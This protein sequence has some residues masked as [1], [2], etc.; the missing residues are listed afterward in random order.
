MNDQKSYNPWD[1]MLEQRLQQVKAT[2]K[3]KAWEIAAIK[4]EWR[5]K[6][7]NLGKTTQVIGERPKF[8]PVY[9][10]GHNGV[11]MVVT[12]ADNEIFG[13]SGSSFNRKPITAEQL[14]RQLEYQKR[15]KEADAWIRD[16]T[17]RD[18]EPTWTF[19]FR[20][21]LK[22]KD[23]ATEFWESIEGDRIFLTLTFIEDIPHNVGVKILNKLLTM[24][25]REFPGLEYIWCAEQQERNN[26]RLHFHLIMNK[27][28]PVA[29]YNGLWVLQQYNAGLRACRAGGSEIDLWEIEC[30]HRAGLVGKVLNPATMR[31]ANDISGLNSY[32]T[33]YVS[34]QSEKT[35][36]GCRV[37]HCSRGVSQMFTR[38]VTFPAT[39]KRMTEFKVNPYL[40]FKT[41]ECRPIRPVHK[42]YCSSVFIHRKRAAKPH[43]GFMVQTNKWVMKERR[44]R[45]AFKWTE[46]AIR[47]SWI[48]QDVF[49][50][51]IFAHGIGKGYIDQDVGINSIVNPL[52]AARAQLLR[53]FLIEYGPLIQGRDDI[54]KM[55]LEQYRFIYLK[56]SDAVIEI[57]GAELCP[58]RSDD[59]IPESRERPFRKKQFTLDDWKNFAVKY[60]SD[61]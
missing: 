45:P 14:L 54:P 40:D 6:A 30:L 58:R 27:F 60:F 53:K 41:G 32:L 17:G 48:W 22:F 47:A 46:R 1:K 44:S 38:E 35:K 9:R 57:D 10:I 21:R 15:K 24:L 39:F 52:D 8:R 37:W 26:N 7:A 16:L 25:R 13:I 43:V 2:G 34:K 59:D 12:G 18:P 3:G 28:L 42:Q 33:A 49:L 29:R 23:K 55:S 31:K 36:Y 56:E 19:S 4:H 11:S 51:T 20:S 50:T 5:K 61:N